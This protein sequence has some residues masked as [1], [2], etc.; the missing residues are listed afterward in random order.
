MTSLRNRI[1]D[2]LDRRAPAVPA[3]SL[4]DEQR[5]AL[6]RRHGDFSLAYSTATQDGL[7]YFGGQD[8][9]IAFQT[10]MGR[11]FVLGDP[12]ADPAAR[13]GLLARFVEAAGAPWFVQVGPR[14]AET[15]AGL[16]YLVNRL[17]FDTALPLPA[18]DF[19]GSR[20][21]T[22]RYSERWLGKKGFV[23]AEDDGTLV[24]AAEVEALST[25]WRAGRIVSRRE[26]AFLNRPFLVTPGPLMRRFVLTDDAGKLVA[27]LDYDPMFSDGEVIGYTTAFKRKVAGAT[28]HA[29]IGL[30]KFSVDRFRAEGVPNVTLGL[31]PLAAIAPAALPKARCG[32]PPSPAPSPPAS[33]TAPAS[34]CKGRRLSSAASTAARSRS[35][36]PFR[37]AAP[38]ACWRFCGWSRRSDSQVL[39][40]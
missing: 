32:V 23:L 27:L 36:S 13:A 10:K 40:R 8:G 3:A 6:L 38:S 18:T 4:A 33:S 17:G 9:Y 14:T 25:E 15:L 29:E 20:N 37:K 35:T 12:V 24:S 22:V 11:H 31:S 21:E 39:S 5:L 26:M 7:S 28:P 30:T 1:D 2:F 19:S 16:G 34:T